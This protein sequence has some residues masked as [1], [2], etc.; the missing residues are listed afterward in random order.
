MFYPDQKEAFAKL[1]TVVKGRRVAVLGHMRPDGDCIGSQIALTR[2]LLALGVDA[3]AVNRHPVPRDIEPIVQ[4]TPFLLWDEFTSEDHIAINVDCADPIRVSQKLV[5]IFPQSLAN[6]DHHI[7]NPGYAD[8]NIIE[9]VSAA[10]CEVLAGLF[11]DF[12]LPVD[13][14]TAQALYVGIATDTGQ[15]RFP[16]T[17]QQVFKICSRL[18]DCGASP[19]EAARHLFENERFNKLA[20]LQRFLASLRLELEGRVCIGRLPLKAYHDTGAWRE[21]AE[22]FVDYARDIAEVEIGILLEEYED[23]TLK[24]SLRA[25][26]AKYRVDQ[27]A[28]FFGGGGHTCAAGFNVDSNIEKFYHEI[29]AKLEE[30]LADVAPVEV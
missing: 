8:I 13:A 19:N 2:V 17:T 23:G 18:M 27:V 25:K 22:G 4:D 12:D 5:D 3:V 20:L 1:L 24:G 28:K 26:D 11:F 21:E 15:F 7:S 10:T 16:S 30:H 6:I 14:V 9:P 29:V